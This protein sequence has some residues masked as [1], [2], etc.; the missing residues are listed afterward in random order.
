MK[1]VKVQEKPIVQKVKGKKVDDKS[2]PKIEEETI[3]CIDFNR[4]KCIEPQSH[5]GRFGGCEGV[6][7]QH[8]CRTCWTEKGMKLGHPEKDD[9]CPL[10]GRL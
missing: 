9:R 4:G 5:L 6:L 1:V 3:Y 10:K 8:I 2:K 7:K